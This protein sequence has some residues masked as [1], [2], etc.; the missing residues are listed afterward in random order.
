MEC[1]LSAFKS[2]SLK[3]IDTTNELPVVG[4]LVVKGYCTAME[5]AD[6]KVSWSIFKLEMSIVSSKFRITIPV[7]KLTSKDNSIGGVVSSPNCPTR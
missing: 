7:L 6:C 2:A 5:D 4:M 1:A 3:A